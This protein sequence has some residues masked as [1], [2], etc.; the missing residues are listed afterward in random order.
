MK[1]SKMQVSQVPDNAIKNLS[2][3]ILITFVL[4]Y[5]S[6]T[7]SETLS[8]SCETGTEV[9]RFHVAAFAI[10]NTHTFHFLSLIQTML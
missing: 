6:Q 1:D 3:I 4:R 9:S 8:R 2:D 10:S 7:P 5:L